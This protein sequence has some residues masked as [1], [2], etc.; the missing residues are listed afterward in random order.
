[1]Q[2]AVKVSDVSYS[3]D[4]WKLFDQPGRDECAVRLNQAF[5]DL[6]NSG[7][8]RTEVEAQ[9]ESVLN[10]SENANL[11]AADSEGYYMMERLLKKVFG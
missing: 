2:I 10:R 5:A 8:S 6:V 3:A 1:M 9:F 7:L 11:G 4:N